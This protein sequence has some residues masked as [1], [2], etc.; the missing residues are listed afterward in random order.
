LLVSA[1]TGTTILIICAD[2]E[3]TVLK[4]AYNKEM[5]NQKTGKNGNNEEKSYHL[6]HLN[7]APHYD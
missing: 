6:F 7:T 3:S 1:Q 5:P 2:E 4:E